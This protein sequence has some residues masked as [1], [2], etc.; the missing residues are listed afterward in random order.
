MT[1]DILEISNIL[2]RV[3]TKHGISESELSRQIGA[4]RAT[5]NRLVSGRTPDPRASTLQAIADFFNIS[6]D[7]LLGKQ[8]LY[9]NF[10]Q[11]IIA[12]TNKS[13]PIIDWE[14][15][16]NWESLIKQLKSD[17]SFSWVAGDQS[18]ENGLFALKLS[19]EAM[20]PQ[21]Q[22]GTILFVDPKK[23]IKNKDF[24]VSYVKKND[25]IVLRQ[26]TLEGKYRFLKAINPIF[27]IIQMGNQDEI[28]GVVVQARN[29]YS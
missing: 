23:Q 16:K 9:S 24:V 18:M 27:P 5:I 17:N 25:E 13:L 12:T 29:S 6:V 28:I 10:N 8:P 22:E 7:Q 20:W 1:T 2:N 11:D 19:G 21:F 14:E 26:L 3:L 15:A 4:P